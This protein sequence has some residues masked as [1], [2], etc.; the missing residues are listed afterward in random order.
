MSI[1]NALT[2]TPYGYRQNISGTN[3]FKDRSTSYLII[4]NKLKDYRLLLGR[5]STRCQILKIVSTSMLEASFN[6]M[7]YTNSHVTYFFS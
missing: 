4:F 3:S 1:S 6:V 2:A 7:S 5:S